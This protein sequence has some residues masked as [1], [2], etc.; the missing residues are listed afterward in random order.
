M[1]ANTGDRRVANVNFVDLRFQKDVRL[2][3][4][5]TRQPVRRRHEPDQQCGVRNVGSQLGSSSSV[6][7]ADR[8]VYPRRLQVGTKLV[9]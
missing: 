1:E 8:I 3:N 7:R 6:R 4:S 9:W 5:P 2:P